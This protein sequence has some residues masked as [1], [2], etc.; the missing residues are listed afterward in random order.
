VAPA[1]S[2]SRDGWAV[3]AFAGM[4]TLPNLCNG[5]RYPG[6]A[7]PVGPMLRVCLR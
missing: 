2:V 7:R 5:F 6:A 4:T 3:P 1:L